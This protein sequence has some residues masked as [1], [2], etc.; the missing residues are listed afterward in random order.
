MIQRPTS[1][2]AAVLDAPGPPEAL[3]VRQVPVPVPERLDLDQHLAGFNRSELHTR[4]GLADGVVFP[5]VL[6]IEATGVVAECP[7]ASTSPAPRSP[8]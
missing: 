7:G 4:L 6:G 3:E 2:R 1:M 5:R 8:R